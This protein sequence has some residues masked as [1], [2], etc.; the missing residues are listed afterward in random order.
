MRHAKLEAGEVPGT[1]RAT[2]LL[3]ER[4]ILQMARRLA[5]CRLARG[6][7][8]SSPASTFEHLQALLIDKEHE[9]FGA[10]LMNTRHRIIRF[11]ELFRGTIDGASVHPREVVKA[12]LQHNAAAVVLVHNH[13]SGDPEPS[14]SDV[15]ITR[16][17]VE[18]LALV[19]VRVLDHVVVAGDG[20]V[21]FAERGLL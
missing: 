21:S 6:E 11:E 4:D 19:D 7:H 2:S 13:P 17:L 9:I 8:V 3:T 10:L 14:R 18:A 12:A 20:C 5:R 15:R 1:Y 16:R